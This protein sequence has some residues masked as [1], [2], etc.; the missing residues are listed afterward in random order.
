MIP[1]YIA[2]SEFETDRNPHLRLSRRQRS[3]W[4]NLVVEDVLGHKTGHLLVHLK[5]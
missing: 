5:C 1:I 3:S 2:D 4:K